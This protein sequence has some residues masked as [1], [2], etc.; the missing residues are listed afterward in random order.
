M[1]SMNEHVRPRVPR[2]GLHEDLD[3]AIWDA[4]LRRPHAGGLGFF[5][6]TLSK[7]ARH[8]HITA[9]VFW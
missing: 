2:M 5:L 9:D 6:P 3:N 1:M 4:C 8:T 7:P